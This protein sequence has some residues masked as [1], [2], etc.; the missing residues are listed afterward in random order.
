V[1][2]RVFET[3]TC[4]LRP[5]NKINCFLQLLSALAFI[6]RNLEEWFIVHGFLLC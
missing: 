1:M 3:L 5:G 6:L 4:I 2:L